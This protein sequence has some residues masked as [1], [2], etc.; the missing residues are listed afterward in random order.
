MV[1]RREA[2][3]ADE[4]EDAAQDG[5]AGAAVSADEGEFAREP[6]DHEDD[7]DDDIDDPRM[8]PEYTVQRAD[9]YNFFRVATDLGELP[10]KCR[11]P[12]TAKL[13][14]SMKRSG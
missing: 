6:A 11:G 10:R 8:G 2:V 4:N 12:D 14:A 1:S 5:E 3:D 7:P 13:V 9:R